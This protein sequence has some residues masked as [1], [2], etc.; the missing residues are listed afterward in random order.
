MAALALL[1][2][3]LVRWLHWREQRVDATNKAVWFAKV[4]TLNAIEGRTVISL[5]KRRASNALDA[6]LSIHVSFSGC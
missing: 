6:I 5:L 2:V 3:L 4:Q 1:T